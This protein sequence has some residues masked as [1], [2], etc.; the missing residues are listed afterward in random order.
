MS[1]QQW[2]DPVW[3]DFLGEFY[4]MIWAKVLEMERDDFM[5]VATFEKIAPPAVYLKEEF[6]R[7]KRAQ[8]E[9]TPEQEAA[10]DSIGEPVD[11]EREEGTRKRWKRWC[12]PS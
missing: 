3:W 10:R 5:A 6:E 8:E 7:W 1:W 9:L 2:A 12:R 11:L 4:D